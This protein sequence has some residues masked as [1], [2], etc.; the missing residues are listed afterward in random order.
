MKNTDN[1]RESK[2]ASRGVTAGLVAVLFGFTISSV[3][4]ADDPSAKVIVKDAGF[5]RV[6]KAKIASVFSMTESNVAASA[7]HVL[8]MGRVVPAI[9]DNGDVVFYA[10][11]YNSAFTDLNVYWVKSGP[12]PTPVL[13]SVVPGSTPYPTSFQAMRRGENQSIFRGD[14]IRE[15]GSEL[16]DPIYWRLISS[17]LS[18][19]NFNA[20]V[21]MD[22]VAASTGGSLKVRV[23]GATDI[24]G[25]YYHRARILLNNTLL[26]TFDFEGLDSAEFT[27]SV[28]SGLFVNGNNTIRVQSNPPAGT[29]FDSFYL[30]FLEATYQRQ[31]TAVS[32]RL[33]IPVT[34][35]S[36]EISSLNNS[37]LL[38]WNVTDP[39]APSQLVGAQ[40]TQVGTNYKINFNTTISG[41]YAVVR[42]G[43]ELAPLQV[44]TGSI[45]N[46]KSC[47]WE[48]DHLTIS[49]PTLLNA[50]LS[51]KSHRAAQGLL[52][53]AIT[54]EDVYDSF[55]FGIR[56]PRA[57]QA[58]LGYAYRN[59]AKSPGYVFLMGDGSLDYKNGMGAND[60]GIPS[61]PVVVNG[62]MYA[63]DYMFGDIDGDGIVEIA[64]GRLPVNTMSNAT[65]FVEKM[66]NYE[67]GGN[68]RTNT[69]ITTDLSDYA[70][71]FYNDGNYL[72]QAIVEREVHRADMD[73]IGAS[74]TRDEIIAGVNQ[75]KE[76]TV[77]IGHGTPNQL[78]LQS[79]I[80]SSDSVLFTNEAAPSTFVMI[81]CLVGSFA[82]PAFTGFG[83]SMLKAKGGAASMMAAATLISAADGR[84]FS[85]EFLDTLY[86]EGK[87][88]IGD[89]WIN[90]KNGL[91]LAGRAPA[92]KA[93]QLLGD[94]GMSVGDP[95]APAEGPAQ[96]PSRGTYE[97]WKSWAIPVVLQDAGFL[98]NESDDPDGDQFNNWSEFMAGT[99][100]LN[101]ESFLE[102]VEIRKGANVQEKL[103]SWPSAGGRLYTLE[104]STSINGPYVPISQGI[105][106]TAPLNTFVTTPGNERYFYR[107]A[108]E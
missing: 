35:G 64:V 2:K 106:A 19:S 83:E 21:T 86:T 88:R 31:F 4:I 44:A 37:N 78:S 24:A 108:V 61:M 43:S 29:T 51:V 48:L 62:G 60:S 79:I 45:Y 18:T 65:Q 14:I 93:F 16:E 102:I 41:S 10:H 49:E 96:G 17:G 5:Y 11:R 82:N 58:F 1:D 42:L 92:F 15:P 53:E 22:A 39:W 89:A 27:F 34:S 99:D 69:L 47:D 70:G 8:N 87:S 74:A 9:R 28:P 33:T 90:G 36:F 50:A 66:I 77:Y 6:T 104:Y 23:K 72:E 97:E 52:A 7:F 25:R 81:G 75:G 98:T 20:T 3:A 73:I 68:W 105:E 54:I 12:G 32:N 59:W 55:N 85:E 101:S 76:V 95:E 57:I 94:P 63:T 84:V 26:G 80:L 38:C 100:A 13:Q 67:V 91:T 103:V 56:D 40:V 46:L 30:D 71:A 107:V